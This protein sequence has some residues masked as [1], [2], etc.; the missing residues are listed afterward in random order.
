MKIILLL[1]T[2]LG[3]Q[4]VAETRKRIV[5]IDEAFSRDNSEY[6]CKD[7]PYIGF[8][9]SYSN[10][11]HGKN[12]VGLIGERIDTAKYCI[13][14][15]SMFVLRANGYRDAT[16]TK[17]LS[18]AIALKNTIWVNLSVSG[19]L[20]LVE[21]LATIQRAIGL[22]IGFSVAAGNN[23]RPV[24]LGKQCDIFPAC[25][26]VHRDYHV[27]SS[28]D[29]SKRNTGTVVTHFETGHKLGTPVLSGTSQATAV[30]TGNL[31]RR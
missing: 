18:M 24:N 13:T 27:V 22:G 28:T 8:G 15:M 16:F 3:L 17:Q 6:L 21:E 26:A 9:P 29:T 11:G 20:G 7:F 10:T 5:V 4:A 25:Y 14:F 1:I 2:I 19:E 31:F 30:H 23:G 12:I